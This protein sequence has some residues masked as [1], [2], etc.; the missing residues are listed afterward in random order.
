MFEIVFAHATHP[1]AGVVMGFGYRLYPSY[2]G[3]GEP[4]YITLGS[5]RGRVVVIVHTPR[6]SSTRIVSMRKAN[7]RERASYQKFLEAARHAKG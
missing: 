3:Y 7:E 6:G 4:R 2:A 5:L 1:A